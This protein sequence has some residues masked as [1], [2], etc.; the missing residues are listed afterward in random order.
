MLDYDFKMF[1]QG[2]TGRISAQ[3]QSLSARDLLA[4]VLITAMRGHLV[5]LIAFINEFYWELVDVAKS[6]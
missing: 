5:K 3:S 1:C 6:R 4:Q 2:L